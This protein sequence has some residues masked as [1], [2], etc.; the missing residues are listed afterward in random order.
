MNVPRHGMARY[1]M[2]SNEISI[3]GL[4]IV[5]EDDLRLEGGVNQV[6]YSDMSVSS[7]TCTDNSGSW[8]WSARVGF[9]VA[10][11]VNV[12][13]GRVEHWVWKVTVRVNGWDNI[14]LRR[15]NRRT[16]SSA[17]KPRKKGQPTSSNLPLKTLKTASVQCNLGH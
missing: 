1:G 17:A 11:V 8:I 6:P 14:D 16:T 9:V 4:E 13:M 5:S 10:K 12:N 15:A 2:R 3:F 7:G